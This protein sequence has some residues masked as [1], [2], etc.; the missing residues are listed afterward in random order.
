MSSVEIIRLYIILLSSYCLPFIYFSRGLI[1]LT[2]FGLQNTLIT[3]FKTL[4][5]LHM[6]MLGGV[7]FFNKVK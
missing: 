2:L 6:D 5:A 3:M 1:T 7:F 4:L